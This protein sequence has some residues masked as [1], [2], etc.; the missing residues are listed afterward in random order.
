MSSHHFLVLPYHDATQ[1]GTLATAV[2]YGLPVIAPDFGCFAETYSN[3]SAI[4]Y[5]QEH[6]E[7]ALT[8][9]SRFTKDD[10]NRM[11]LACR[12]VTDANSEEK[13]AE[14]YIWYFNLLITGND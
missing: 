6:L 2:A 1:S 4:L 3:E 5:P 7:E 10:Y 12:K 8:R 13:I 9:V 11:K 14:N